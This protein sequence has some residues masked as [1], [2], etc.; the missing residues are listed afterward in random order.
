[1]KRKRKQVLSIVPW[2]IIGAALGYYLGMMVG[3]EKISGAIIL[4]LIIW[5]VLCVIIHVVI[6]EAGHAVGGLLTGYKLVSFRIF[7]FMW[8]W[9]EDGQLVFRR[10][11]VPGTL[12]QCL[13]APPKIDQRQFPFRIYLLGGV[14]A[15][16]VA[17]LFAGVLFMPESLMAMTFVGIGV[18]FSVTN[19]IPMDF[20]DGMT[21]RLAS[22]SKE[23]AYLL[24]LQLEVNYQFSLGNTY[25]DLPS[26]Y[27]DTVPAIP[28]RTYFNDYQESLQLGKLFEEQRL[29]E[30]SALLE[31]LWKRQMD[32][33]MP[34]QLEVKRA[35]LV[36]LSASAPQDN[37]VEQLWSDK[38]LQVYLKQPRM[39]NKAALAAYYGLVEKKREQARELLME[40]QALADNAPNSGSAKIDNQELEWIAYLLDHPLD[41]GEKAYTE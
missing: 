39:G 19:A 32:R 21:L 25:N 8:V 2:L 14:T 4:Q 5:L 34:Y 16:L 15:N 7:S 9:Q 22:L 18:F 11:K 3:Q 33:I 41:I 20:N 30:Y 23:Q 13:M 10:Y 27:F 24:F 12:G 36:W 6:H 29:S 38:K 17:S 1:M 40:G 37:R 31:R 28:K 35:M 26:C